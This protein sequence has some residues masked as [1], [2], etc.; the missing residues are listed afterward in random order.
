ME[1]QNFKVGFFAGI[2]SAGA[3]AFVMLAIFLL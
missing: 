3:I 1:K 2:C